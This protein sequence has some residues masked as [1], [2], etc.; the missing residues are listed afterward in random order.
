[1]LESDAAD[2][3]AREAELVAGFDEAYRRFRTGDLEAGD[4]VIS[5]GAELREVRQRIRARGR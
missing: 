4:R 2:L 1:M 5:L 3:R